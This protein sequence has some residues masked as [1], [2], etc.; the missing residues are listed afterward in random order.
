[1]G[2][3]ISMPLTAKVWVYMS[4][5]ALTDMESQLVAKYAEEYA[6][7]WAAHGKDL[8]AVAELRYNRFLIFMVDE[9]SNSAGGCSIDNSTQFIAEMGKQ[10]QVDFFNRLLFAYKDADGEIHTI[11]QSK[12]KELSSTG[13]IKHETIVYNNMVQTIEDLKTKWEVPLRDSFYSR[14]L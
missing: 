11:H 1:M 8:E 4:D 13:I 7:Q 14:F 6:D 2:N 3:T 10:L 9:T 5:R 12:I